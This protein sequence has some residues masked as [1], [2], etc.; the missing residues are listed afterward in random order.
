MGE[1]GEADGGMMRLFGGNQT[2][3]PSPWL[4]VRKFEVPG[5]RRQGRIPGLIRGDVSVMHLFDF[6]RR[7]SM[8]FLLF[9]VHFSQIF[10]YDINKMKTFP[11]Y[12]SL[13]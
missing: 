4:V 13:H 7:R 2:R 3:K 9:F 12:D 1:L 5:Q 10:G 6:V 8:R 11:C